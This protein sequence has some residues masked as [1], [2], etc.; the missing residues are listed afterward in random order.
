MFDQ[1]LKYNIIIKHKCQS[2]GGILAS[3]NVLE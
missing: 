1:L 2:D 3:E